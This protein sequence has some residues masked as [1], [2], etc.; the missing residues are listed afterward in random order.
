MRI[1][2]CLLILALAIISP[3]QGFSHSPEYCQKQLDARINAAMKE[4]DSGVRERAIKL[5]Q[6]RYKICLRTEE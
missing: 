3:P 1:Q 2:V 5:S 4:K 6:A